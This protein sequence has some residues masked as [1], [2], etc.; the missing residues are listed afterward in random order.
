M[1]YRMVAV[2]TIEEKVMALKARKQSL[3]AR[4]MDDD[5]LLSAPLSVDDI[6]GLFG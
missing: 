6:K 5:A 4:V 2:G 1:V 3:F